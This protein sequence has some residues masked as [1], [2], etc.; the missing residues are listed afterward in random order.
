MSIDDYVTEDGSGSLRDAYV[1]DLLPASGMPVKLLLIFESPHL[2]E[3]A[4]GTPVVGGAG[5]SALE[6][7]LG[8]ATRGSLGEFV[9]AMHTA[10]DYR[11]AVMNV[12]NVPLQ[13]QAFD[14]DAGPLTPDEWKVIGAVR[15]STAREV[16]GTMTPEAN[17][18]GTIIRDGLQGRVSRLKFESGTA[19]VL[20]GDFVQRFAR[21]LTGLPGEPLKVFHP[22]RNLWLNNPDRDEHKTLRK[23]F[24]TS[25]T[26]LNQP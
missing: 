20:C 5:Q 6:Y 11:V 24:L 15:D 16:D 4:A 21:R 8:N 26:P 14:D 2:E 12:S 3:V 22:S 9:D 13:P 25:A 1:R 18:I 7:L 10:G 17:R 19:V 23:L